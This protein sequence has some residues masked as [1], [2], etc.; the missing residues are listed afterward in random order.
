MK[1]AVL[2]PLKD[3]YL[4]VVGQGA[5]STPKPETLFKP[6]NLSQA[7][8]ASL[9]PSFSA[10]PIKETSSAFETKAGEKNLHK[11]SSLTPTRKPK[12]L[13]LSPF[14]SSS[15]KSLFSTS[16]TKDKAFEGET[17]AGEVVSSSNSSVKPEA[18]FES[19]KSQS[20]KPLFSISPV[21]EDLPVKTF[22]VT[23]SDISPL[24]LNFKAYSDENKLSYK[25]PTSSSQS[26]CVSKTSSKSFERTATVSKPPLQDTKNSCDWE[27]FEINKQKAPNPL[28]INENESSVFS[29]DLHLND[30]EL[31][32]PVLANPC[33]R[34]RPLF[35][36]GSPTKYL[37]ADNVSERLSQS[38]SGSPKQPGSVSKYITPEKKIHP[39]LV[40]KFRK[41]FHDAL[42]KKHK[43]S[44]GLGEIVS[45]NSDNILKSE[46]STSV[47]VG[48]KTSNT[49][50]EINCTPK[51][52]VS[53]FKSSQTKNKVTDEKDETQY[54]V[55]KEKPSKAEKKPLIYVI[56]KNPVKQDIQT[57]GLSDRQIAKPVSISAAVQ[58]NDEVTDAKNEK[59]VTCVKEK[60]AEPKNI[61]LVSVTA[62]KPV[63]EDIQTVNLSGRKKIETVS[64]LT[65][66][67]IAPESESKREKDKMHPSGNYRHGNH[68]QYYQNNQRYENDRR[69]D[70]YNA[71]QATYNDPDRLYD[72]Y[73]HGAVGNRHYGHSEVH[74]K[75]DW[76]HQGDWRHAN[77]HR[78]GGHHGHGGNVSHRNAPYTKPSKPHR[79]DSHSSSPDKIVHVNEA[80]QQMQGAR[81]KVYTETVKV[82]TKVE[83]TAV[84]PAPEVKKPAP[85]TV[86]AATVNINEPVNLTVPNDANLNTDAARAAENVLPP[87]D[88]P[89]EE[90][91]EQR[92]AKLNKVVNEVVGYKETKSELSLTVHLSQY[93]LCSVPGPV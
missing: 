37:K 4:K 20:H 12:L 57:G 64:N 40:R 15:N 5:S 92:V 63:K 2:S 59:Q 45:N 79:K 16:V 89:K 51:E 81:P 55:V 76:D 83:T 90:T 23:Q 58:A 74:N 28:K 26:L 30:T 75:D 24:K 77:R 71:P 53:A 91:A 73:D 67:D 54:I 62:K 29:L 70:R 78:F 47:P 43:K 36:I 60:T 31:D 68:N 65:A 1:N 11:V 69:Y 6:S 61:S 52:K 46:S 32:L 13:K 17:Q 7:K 18:F 72:P 44:H 25:D 19:T 85:A 84:N 22:S 93:C 49:G 34:R 48:D 82:E 41:S 56:A 39:K 66:A 9:E 8:S 21:K 14:K 38:P 10:S 35:D 87:P 33:K 42:E 3:K 50:S 80:R 86:T 27:K 88:I